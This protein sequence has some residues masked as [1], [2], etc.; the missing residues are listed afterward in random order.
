MQLD[1]HVLS[2]CAGVAGAPAR[3]RART[4]PIAGHGETRRAA[5][6]NDQPDVGT[7]KAVWG[8]IVPAAT[9][10]FLSNGPCAGL[11]LVS[12]SAPQNVVFHRRDDQG[13]S[14]FFGPRHWRVEGRGVICAPHTSFPAVTGK[15]RI[16]RQQNKCLELGVCS[17]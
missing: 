2:C 8:R 10:L 5:R 11:S 13:A 16:P 12:T 14:S 7:R 17:F 6:S 4:V 9:A 15:A 1:S 3:I